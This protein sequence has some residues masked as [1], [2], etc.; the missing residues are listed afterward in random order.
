MT[1]LATRLSRRWH[2]PHWLRH[3]PHPS[4]DPA[5]QAAYCLAAILPA[6]ISAACTPPNIPPQPAA[7]Y[8]M[9]YRA[10]TVTRAWRLEER[11]GH[12]AVLRQYADGMVALGGVPWFHQG[13]DRTCGQA[14]IATLLN[15]WGIPKSYPQVVKEMNP[16]NLPTDVGRVSAYLR[17]QGLQVQD[18][19][20]ATLNFLHQQVA[21]GRPTLVLLDFGS[22]ATTHYVTVKGYDEAG[23]RLLISDPVAGP[24]TV[25]DVDEF[26]RLWRNTSLARLPGVGDRYRFIAFDVQGP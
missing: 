2:P 8:A 13:Q 24:N 14:N 25:M 18:Y 10:A 20:L 6:V 4:H 17:R 22:L 7:G 9:D 12:R 3:L 15:F 1:A 26:Q 19:R 5:W 21:S 16:G 11:N 23:R